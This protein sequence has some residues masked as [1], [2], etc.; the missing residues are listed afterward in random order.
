MK[1]VCGNC[2]VKSVDRCIFWEGGGG[3][4]WGGGEV[5]GFW[6]L[7]CSGAASSEVQKSYSDLVSLCFRYPHTRPSNP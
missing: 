7:T 1:R 6:N 5:G 3:G 2:Q 4:G